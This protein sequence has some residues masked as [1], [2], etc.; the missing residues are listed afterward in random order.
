MRGV[1]QR[2]HVRVMAVHAAVGDQPKQMQ[3]M[4]ARSTKGV[5]QNMIPFQFAI[6]DGLIN[7]GEVL[8]NDPASS[9]IKVAN[10]GVTHLSFRQANVH[11]AGAQSRPG[12][13][14]I[15]TIVK[16]RGR[17]QCCVAVLFTLLR[18]AGIDAPPIANDEHY[19]ASHVFRTL[20]MNENKDK[21][22]FGSVEF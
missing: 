22:F 8:I 16:R 17:E 11:A 3:S 20:P 10:L 12:I 7:P 5:L 9:E 19:G 21:Q 13:I 4:S 14:A 6:G 18:A 1:R 15:Q 2:D